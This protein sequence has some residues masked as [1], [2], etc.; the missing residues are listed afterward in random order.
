MEAD[1]NRVEQELRVALA[2]AL[3][4]G[5]VLIKRSDVARNADGRL[6]GVCLMTALV[7]DCHLS[8][9]IAASEKLKLS[10]S[11]VMEIIDGWDNYPESSGDWWDLGER[12]RKEFIPVRRHYVPGCTG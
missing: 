3:S 6:L 2:E 9:V 5:L 7:G 1:T 11:E 12:L 10:D 4:K 8:Y